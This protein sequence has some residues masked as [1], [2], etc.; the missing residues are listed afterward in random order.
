[1]GKPFAEPTSGTES[2]A[3]YSLSPGLQIRCRVFAFRGGGTSWG[4]CLERL[5]LSGEG[6]AGGITPIKINRDIALARVTVSSVVLLCRHLIRARR[7]LQ[8]V[9]DRENDEE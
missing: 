3:S 8:C 2:V 5:L 4:P 6:F 9:V 1:V 7:S